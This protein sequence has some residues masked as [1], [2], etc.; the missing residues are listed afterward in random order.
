MFS[1][2]TIQ[3]AW[4]L[5]SDHDGT[6]TSADPDMQQATVNLLADMG[7][8]PLTLTS[9]LTA[10][11]A[12][13]DHTAPTSRVT[14]PA[15]GASIANGAQVTATGTASDSGGVVA[16]VEVSTDGGATWHP[17]TGTTSW[18]YT[19]V[20]HGSGSVAI[21]SRA[22]DDS[23]N[24]ETPSAGVSVT[25]TCPCSLFGSLTPATGDGADGSDT[26]LGVRFTPN[27]S[28]FV[29]GIRFYKAAANT[30]THTGTLWSSGGAVLATGTFSAETS[31]GWQ[32]LTFASPIPVTAG[33]TYVASYRAPK[34]HYSADENFFSVAAWNAG[35]LTAPR[36]NGSSEN[37][38]YAA[39][40]QFPASDYNDT[41]YYVD[42]TFSATGTAVPVV[43]ST[44]PANG[45]VGVAVGSTISATMSMPIQAGTAVMSVK[46]SGG[47][48]VS[49]ATSYNAATQTV[50]FTPS[51][52]LA[53][54][55]TYTVTLSGATSSSGGVMSPVTWSFTTASADGCPC[56]LFAG[57]AV[58]S[59]AD[60]GDASSVELGVRFTPSTSG[61]VSGIRFYKASTNTG[62]HTGTLWSSAGAVLATGTF[63]GESGS[64]WQT[65]TFSSPVAVTAGSTYT[66]SYLAPNGHYSD[67]GGF[68]SADYTNGSLTAPAANNGV[69][70]YGGG[71]TFPAST[72]NASNYWVDVLFT[73]G[74]AVV[75]P[76]VT[77]T[78]PVGGATGVAASTTV[79]AT[80]STA[81][82]SAS[83]TMGLAT[84]GGT[85]VTGTL[86]YNATTKTATF[87]P[88]AA[89]TA[90]ATYT[91]T[92]SAAKDSAGTAM[93]A[94]VTWSFT[95]AAS[96]GGGGTCPCTLFPSTSVPTTVDAGDGS[97]VELG[98]V[99]TSSVSGSVTGVTF[100]KAAANTGT[101]TGTL[102][103]STGAVL[104][105]GTF[106]GE[107]ASGW[108][109]LTFSS[110]VA[111][112]AGTSYTASYHTTTGHYSDDQSYFASNYTSGPLTAP[113]GAN[114]VY[115][116]GS[117]SVQP[118]S[119]WNGSNYWV[120]P[121]FSTS[122]A[123][124]APTVTST[125]PASAA[126]GVAAT[127]TV[128][129]TFSTAMQSSSIVM[130]LSAQ[131]GSAVTGSTSYNSSTNTVTFTPAAAL[132]A[133]TTYTAT[134]SAA[135]SSQSVALAA[136]KTWSFT[137]AAAAGGSGCPCSLFSTSTT[138][139]NVETTD[140]SSVELGVRFTPSS[141]GTVTGV[142]FYKA[143]TNTGTHTGSLWSSS[144]TRLAT[145]TFTGETASGWQTLTFT[146]PVAVTAGTTYTASYLA[147]HGNYSFAANY[148]ASAYTNGPLTAPSS[149]GNGVYVYGSGGTAP[150]STWNA[151]NYWVDVL[152]S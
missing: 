142:R 16:G 143:S 56:S 36:A 144:G 18:S 116:Y 131:G 63:S 105:T 122:V 75:A 91:A 67:D 150:T 127:A 133:S 76:T 103:S 5:D 89:L 149:G 95:V 125:S 39:G 8:Q 31:S 82:Q 34:G 87:T 1:A 78:S 123:A 93:A 120:S 47:T 81:M 98:V 106:S 141:S 65:L 139:T 99:F 4:G 73:P 15:A 113:A 37:G 101:H 43:S 104:A 80:F 29:N 135:T 55:T 146:T 137:T 72:W 70:A 152:F 7:A 49:G 90:G 114:G 11:A 6:A 59:V 44:T 86:A 23:G 40:G 148:F 109:T 61:S 96:G 97:G 119:S 115:A 54:T 134:I 52:A 45:Q 117:G 35:P 92:V 68:F 2:G 147:P 46:N 13:A 88:S 85:A 12:S 74:A 28:G 136:P 42:V 110:P 124:P 22:T 118:T 10:S 108:Q 94:P 151:T 53:V 9:G 3:W 121:V 112:T 58:P 132:T 71:G 83:I 41:N 19:F 128:S 50:T 51:A 130:S 24:I 33:T 48:A 140:T 32:T 64:G 138:P 26:E 38:V 107:S 145:G 66:A 57:N 17:A 25:E 60:A 102:W 21:K 27:A 30:G 129:A 14:S 79:A 84:S 100:Y 20:A 77:S 69:Y 111:V 62:T 126:T